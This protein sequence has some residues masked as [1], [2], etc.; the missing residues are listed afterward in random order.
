MSD[1]RFRR[2]GEEE[3]YDGGDDRG[4]RYVRRT[5]VCQFCVEKIHAVDY[6]QVEVLRKYINERGKIRPRRQT[7]NCAKHQRI[8]AEAVKRSRHMALLPYDGAEV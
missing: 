4:A 6:K 7:G 3:E 5:R 2:N 1:E 8:I